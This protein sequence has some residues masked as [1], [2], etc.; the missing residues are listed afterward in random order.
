MIQPLI[1]NSSDKHIEKKCRLQV[2]YSESLL[3]S[4]CAPHC[5]LLGIYNIILY[6]M[7]NQCENIK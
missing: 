2:I 5:T 7:N 3:T 6:G 1:Q 4:K